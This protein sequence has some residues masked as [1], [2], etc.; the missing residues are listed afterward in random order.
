MC[1]IA[2]YVTDEFSTDLPDS[3][4]VS[5]LTDKI[6]SAGAGDRA[7]GTLGDVIGV[8][9]KRFGEMMAI[10]FV[11]AVALDADLEAALRGLAARLGEHETAL[12]AL[13]EAGRTDLD[14]LIEG[15]R[16][17]G[18]QLEAEL[19]DHAATARGLVGPGIDLNTTTALHVAI[20]T[21]Y[22]LRA[23]DRLEVRGRDSAGIAIQ[24]DVPAE[25]PGSLPDSEAR[26]LTVRAADIHAGHDA[27]YVTPR[28]AGGTTV[29]F[30]YKTANL[31]GRLG[32]NGA[33]LRDALRDDSLY[34]ALASR[35]RRV[36]ILSH[37]RW[38]S[39]GVISVANCHPHNPSLNGDAPGDAK[40]A[41]GAMY[42]LNGDVDNH[43]ELMT[44]LVTNRQSAVDAAITTDIIVGFPGETEADFEAMMKL[45]EDVNFDNSFSFI[46]SKRPGTPAAELSEQ[47]PLAVMDERLHRL[48]ALVEQHRQEFNHAMVGRTVEV[49]VAP[50]EGRKDAETNRMSGRARDNRLVHFAVPEGA[51]HPRPGDMVTVEVTYGGPALTSGMYYQF[52]VTSFKDTPNGSTALSRT[53]DLR[54]VFV[55]E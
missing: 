16:D 6:A 42:A 55:V 8:L 54:G 53:E 41:L 18:W 39:H 20:A 43:V 9:K 33:A 24:L 19:A 17:F 47:V 49:L 45:V 27:V 21:E 10:G 13:S 12:T 50:S 35:A 25:A 1:G 14:P 52:R 2:G 5:G 15:L 38:A 28:D 34:W 30:I 37:T 26:A 4:F 23:N 48:Q 32:D 29:T 40:A 11:R 36:S 44:E 46:F 3:G 22:V 51:E 31:V 7:V